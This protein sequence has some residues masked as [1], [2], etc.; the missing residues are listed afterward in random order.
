MRRK[1]SLR[2]LSVPAGVRILFWIA[3]GIRLY[4]AVTHP[5]GNF[6]FSDM[7]SYHN[8]A[9]DL[10]AGRV[11]AWHAFRPIGYSAFL[12]T[13]YRWLGPELGAVVVGAVQA[14][15]SAAIV[16]LAARTVRLLGGAG[17][18]SLLAA[19]LV[20]ISVPLVYYTGFLLTEVPTAFLLALSVAIMLEPGARSI[21][22]V[23]GG[24]SIGCAAAMRPNL[25]P[26]ALLLAA[27]SCRHPSARHRLSR[28]VLFVAAAT[29]PLG[30]AAA[31]NSMALGRTVG[32]ATN[33]GVNFY[34]NFA[35]VRTI[36]Y[37]GSFGRY[38]ITPAPNAFRG[39]R[40]ELTNV[41]FFDEEYYYARGAHFLREHPWALVSGTRNLVEGAGVGE[42][43][44]WP[45][46][47][48]G[49]ES[50][51]HTYSRVFF[52]VI[53]VPSCVWTLC[54]ANPVFRRMESLGAKCLAAICFGGVL[55][56]YFFLGDPRMRV[57]FDPLW[58]VLGSM[59]F[60]RARRRLASAGVPGPSV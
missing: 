28:A 29:L 15:M 52:S 49:Y 34:L 47:L 42:Q 12:A 43:V 45:N 23:A 14:L 16:P 7:L 3:L 1:I 20:T 33:G 37:Q 31:Y 10:V 60:E 22:V 2:D 38:W 40:T 35:D 39:E 27:L 44:F 4:F 36:R 19:A 55:P 57:P 30:A 11:D 59:A 48:E 25:A 41:P 32:P 51:F 17:A 9:L 8:V 18:T 50:L 58:T 46:W 6:L 13:F 5:P 56:I 54:L 26:I 53:L 21:N 24:L